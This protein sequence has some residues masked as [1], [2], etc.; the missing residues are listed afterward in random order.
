M[1]PTP[2]LTRGN[3]SQISQASYRGLRRAAA[4]KSIDEVLGIRCA[5]PCL[6]NSKCGSSPCFSCWLSPLPSPPP[7][8]CLLLRRR[9]PRGHHGGHHGVTT[10]A[11][12][13]GITVIMVD[14]AA[15]SV[16]QHDK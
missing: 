5:A 12:M 10:E 3:G 14:S 8:P 15:T 7:R 4:Y 6:R 9:S 11:I 16:C 1:T 2:Q 13:E